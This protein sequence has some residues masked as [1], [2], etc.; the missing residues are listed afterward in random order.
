MFRLGGSKLYLVAQIQPT[1]KGYFIGLQSCSLSYVL[2]IGVY[3]LQWQF[4]YS[5]DYADC[6]A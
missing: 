2:P 1:Y 4:S 3:M 6:K 5:R